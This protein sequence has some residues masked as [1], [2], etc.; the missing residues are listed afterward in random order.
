MAQSEQA[1]KHGKYAEHRADNEKRQE[2]QN[3]RQADFAAGQ[4]AEVDEMGVECG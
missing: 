4:I 2:Q 3:Q 1:A